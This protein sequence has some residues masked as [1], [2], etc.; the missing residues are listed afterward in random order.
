MTKKEI[1]KKCCIIFSPHPDDATLGCGG[2]II[3]KNREGYSIFVIY[4]TDGRNSHLLKFG[5]KE[6]PTPEKLKLQRNQEEREA[7]KVLGVCEKNLLFLEIKDG[8]LYKY[9][10]K[11]KSEIFQA[12]Q[13]LNPSEIFVPFHND[14]HPDHIATY[15]IVL[16]CI[17]SLG[18]RIMLYEYFVWINPESFN[19]KNIEIR[20][21]SK[22]LDIKRIAILKYKSQITRFSLN[23]SRP[24]L[25]EKFLS[26]FLENDKEFFLVNFN[27]SLR[28]IKLAFIHIKVKVL[29]FTY[30][31]KIWITLKRK[32]RLRI[33]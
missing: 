9:K 30:L 22:E 12:L 23:Q 10:K 8:L 7:M 32:S 2:T 19:F 15:L 11:L 4:M 25:N 27:L 6:K 13:K 17:K 20:D 26:H 28:P 3:Q 5:I 16:D 18:I 33:V 14:R 24:V 29:I 31:I 1:S 21:I